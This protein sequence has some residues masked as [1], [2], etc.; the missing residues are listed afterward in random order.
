M[1]E[2]LSLRDVADIL[3]QY[4]A[5]LIGLPLLLAALAFAV[6]SLTARTYSS[7]TVLALN[8]NTTQNTASASPT[9]NLDPSLLPSAAALTSA[10]QVVA[11]RRLATA[12]NTDPRKVQSAF[13]ARYDESSNAITLTA[14]GSSP[15]RAQARAE[16]ARQD[17][18]QYSDRVVTGVISETYRSRLQQSRL[19]VQADELVIRNLKR[20][21]ATT[22]Q[23]LSGRGQPSGRV[24][25]DAVGL[26]PRFSGNSDLPANPA[27][28]YIAVK[29]AETEARLAS[30]EALVSRL[31]ASLRSPEQL[32]SLARQTTQLNT[33]AEAN[34]PPTPDGPGRA[35]V[36]V[37]G[38]L[39]G[40]L[41]AVLFA[42][43]HHALRRPNNPR[44][45]VAH[46]P[47]HGD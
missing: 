14:K 39:L 6:V 38:F 36:A 8:N 12:W 4:K 24:G 42:F 44:A 7:E 22:P 32:L 30:N 5:L 43:V 11:P 3:G 25:A 45:A 33:L 46:V 29:V 9:S 15:E 19:E 47:Q 2:E 17:F 16:Q 23:V 21:L 18:V 28:A 35:V 37:L 10:Y 13:S 40:G 26:D 27:Y 31:E 34:T 20:S 41:L 1:E